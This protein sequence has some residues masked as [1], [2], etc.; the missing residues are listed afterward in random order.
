[1]RNVPA[2]RAAEDAQRKEK[3]RRVDN[4]DGIL[5]L[6]LAAPFLLVLLGFLFFH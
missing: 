4:F 2:E 6:V 3:Q 1:V 5:L